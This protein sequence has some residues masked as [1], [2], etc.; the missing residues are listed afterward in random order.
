L[1]Y[2]LP[3]PP[4][5]GLQDPSLQLRF[6]TNLDLWLPVVGERQQ[7]QRRN[8]AESQSKDPEIYHRGNVVRSEWKYSERLEYT[9]RSRRNSATQGKLLYNAVN[10]SKPPR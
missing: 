8:R 10:P 1:A 5:S 2:K 4:Q 7:Q 3:L 9:P 6:E